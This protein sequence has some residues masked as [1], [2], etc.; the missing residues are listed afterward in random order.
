ML[1]PNTCLVTAHHCPETAGT[2][3][4]VLYVHTHTHTPMK[5]FTLGESQH[6]IITV[7]YDRHTTERH[8]AKCS[9]LLHCTLYGH[10]RP[11]RYHT[12]TLIHAA[13]HQSWL[14][15]GLIGLKPAEKHNTSISSMHSI[16][17][18]TEASNTQPVCSYHTA[19]PSHWSYSNHRLW[20]GAVL[21]VLLI[22]SVFHHGT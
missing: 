10:C 18:L 11:D 2:P 14:N 4:A 6:C 3:Q 22:N 8:T 12:H 7:T 9:H 13:H 21:Q 5:L 19:L 16:L 15:Q 17:T 20:P 1:T